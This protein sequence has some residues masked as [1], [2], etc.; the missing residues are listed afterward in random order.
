M[1]ERQIVHI[2]DDE[3]SIRQSVGFMLERAGY[4][5]AAWD[6]A[7][8]FLDHA[9]TE[10]IGCI[11]L[12]IY[13]PGIDGLTLQKT[14]K[15]RG[16][17]MPVIIITGGAGATLALNAIQAGAADFLEKPFERGVLIAAI[18]GALETVTNPLSRVERRQSAL[19]KMSRLSSPERSVLDGLAGGLANSAIAI[20]LGVETVR[21]EQH[22]ASLMS[23]LGVRNLPAALNVAFAA[24]CC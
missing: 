3:P 14:L 7:A 21:V 22:R 2:I 10:A 18:E 6:S 19:A 9:D 17:I 23:K 20:E 8:E 1:T 5:V 24:G 15:S 13:M 16:C 4:Q 12:D 11:L